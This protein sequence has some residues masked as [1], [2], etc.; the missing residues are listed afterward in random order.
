MRT[1]AKQK[2]FLK[3]KLTEQNNSG[4]FLKKIDET[5]KNL[6]QRLLPS[7]TRKTHIPYEDRSL[8]ALPLQ[9]ED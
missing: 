3:K 5:V 4:S 8:F 9:I 6:R 1:P 7:F 2:E